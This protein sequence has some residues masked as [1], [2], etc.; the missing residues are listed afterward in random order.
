MKKSKRTWIIS[1]YYHPIVTSTGYYI[2]EIAEYVAAQGIS[3]HVICTN[4]TYNEKINLESPKEEIHNN[5]HIHRIQTGV[6]NK[7]KFLSRIFRLMRSSLLIFFKMMAKIHR[8]DEVLVVTNPAFIVL[9]MPLLK[10]I[11]RTQY[12]VLVHDVFPENIV[13][14]QKI[15]DSSILYKITKSYFDR[16]YS[17]AQ[18]CIC[19]GRDMQEV[20]K[21]KTKGKTEVMVV[22]NW[23]DTKNVYPLERA[24]NSYLNQY[25]LQDKFVLQFAGN[26]GWAQGL[27]NLLAAIQLVDKEDIHFLFIGSGAFE[28][29]LKRT[30][31]ESK[32]KNITHIAYIDRK[33]QNEFLNAC[34]IG[35]VT[36][37]DAMYGLGVPSKSYNIMASGKPLLVCADKHS[38]ISLMVKENRIG[39]VVETNNPQVLADQIITIYD[40]R[41]DLISNLQ[42]P[43]EIAE[44]QFSK[45]KILARY[46][47]LIQSK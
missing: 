46:L 43:R 44:I 19:L 14:I 39:W 15:K 36:L 28:N 4:A 45:E 23:A 41:E 27:N 16:S 33:Y 34:D 1:E 38:E 21:K 9:L 3:T 30:I 7:D 13:A 25:Q 47:A 24:K 40:N 10:L 17:K 8:G 22:P 31:E 12:Q 11:K 18:R 37:N 20:M 6:I 32:L 35:I 26:L 5:V 29:E 42:N 2:T